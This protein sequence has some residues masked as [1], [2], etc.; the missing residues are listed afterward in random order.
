MHVPVTR[1]APLAC[2]PCPQVTRLCKQLCLAHKRR[3]ITIAVLSEA[4]VMQ[5]P[6]DGLRC[7]VQ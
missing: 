2:T 1:S 6:F 7:L 3:P 4:S 5:P